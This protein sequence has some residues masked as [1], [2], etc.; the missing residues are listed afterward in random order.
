MPIAFDNTYARELKGAYVS[1]APQGWAEPDLVLLN[2]AWAAHLGL[3]AEYLQSPEGVA[4]LSGHSAPATAQPIAQAYAG[5]QFG[6]FN[7]QLGDGRAYLLGEVV[8]PDGTRHDIHLK[9]SG[10]TPFSRGGDGRAV[11]GPVLREYLVSE[12]M[13]ALG[14]PTTRALAAC[15]TGDRVLRQHGL[16]PGAVLA[17][18]AS[19]HLRVGT[20]QFF[21]AR[22]QT[23]MVARVADY[24]IARHDP[25][26]SGTEGRYLAFLSRVGARQAQ[27]VAQ[28]MGVGFV[29]GVMN[30]DNCTLSGETIDYGPCAFMDNY[31][32][33]TVFSSIDHGG[34]YAYANQPGILLWNMSRLAEALLPLIDPDQDRAIALAT[35]AVERMQD[36]NR[37]A[38]LSVFARKLG[39]EGTCPEGLVD[40]LHK[41]L[42]GQ[43]VD[44]TRF[45]R[46]LPDA[47]TGT[48]EPLKALFGTGEGLEDWL[49]L[50]TRALD[51]PDLAAERMRAV[52]PVYIPRNHLVER[53][54][55]AASDHG[56][57]NPFLSLLEHVQQPFTLR[58]GSEVYADPAPKDAGP[59][60]TFCGT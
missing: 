51:K 43:G 13:A 15:T 24:A 16:E 20:L 18:S 10:R 8:A 19:S 31:D 41:M 50:L 29:H 59:I 32:P 42:E 11:L 40:D 30:T 14:I 35:E 60:V 44:F 45:F 37:A 17:R 23:D 22:G 57:L 9:G 49:G 55:E 1:V 2:T 26:L 28:W 4:M 21:A 56:D 39:F 33:A 36:D 54:L 38:W 27:L 34:R 48:P 5:H 7:P 12:A 53:A 6:S 47:I 3:D 58:E 25:D 52:N 46:L